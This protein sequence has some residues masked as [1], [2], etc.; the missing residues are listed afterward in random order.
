MKF[1]RKPKEVEAMQWLGSES[2][3]DDIISWSGGEVWIEKERKLPDGTVHN[4]PGLKMKTKYGVGTATKGEWIIRGSCGLFYP[5]SDKD[6]RDNY[7][8]I[9]DRKNECA[10]VKNGHCT[11]MRWA[12]SNESVICDGHD[13]SCVGY[14]VEEE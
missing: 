12:G 7:E 5:C 3:T 11:F 2:S 6:F 9:K 13:Y 1:W 8:A 10:H 4:R 14:L